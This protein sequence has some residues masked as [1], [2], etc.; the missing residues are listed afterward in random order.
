MDWSFFRGPTVFP[1]ARDPQAIAIPTTNPLVQ[2]TNQ[3]IDRGI[4]LATGFA[5]GGQIGCD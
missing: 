1:A 2:F 5:G 3:D 4:G